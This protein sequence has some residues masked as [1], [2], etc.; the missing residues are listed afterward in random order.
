MAFLV[1]ESIDLVFNGGAISWTTALDL[2]GVKGRAVN[3]FFDDIVGFFT[4]IRNIAGELALR[5][6]LC[7]K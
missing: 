2:P 5:N 3:I 4:R 1:S 7:L 6:F